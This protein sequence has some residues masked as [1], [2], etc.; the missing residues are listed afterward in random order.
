M[1]QPHALLVAS[2]GLG[3]LIPIL[4]LGNRLSSVLNIHVTILAVTSGSSSPTETEA[5][6][7]A[8]ARTICQITEIPSVDVDNLVEPDATIFTK[9]VVKMRAMKPAVRDAVKLMKRKPTVMIVDFLGTELM[10]V[11]DD[12]GMTAK[13]VYVPTHAWFLAVMVYLPVLDTVVEGEYVDI[14]EPLK[15]PGCKPV[16]PKELMETML[17]RSGQQYK[18]CVRAGLEVPMSDGV[19]V[20][21]WE[22]LQGNTLAALREDEELSRVMK[23]PVYPIGPIV[24][25]NQHVDKPNSIFEWLDEQRERSVVF[26]CLG[27]GG[28]LTFEQT[29]ELALGL[30]LS[31]Q[32][33]VWVLRRPAS[34]LGAISSDDEQ[35]SASLPEGLAP[36]ELGV[37]TGHLIILYSNGQNDVILY[38]DSR[39]T[40]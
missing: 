23:V 18:E 4:E 29:V 33:F 40:S 7:A 11:A 17:D 30:E 35:V 14:K 27:S 8:A 31:G 12:V 10:S 1:D 37:K 38:R 3:H 24:R 28:T 39:I 16:G 25:T 32:R 34:Y 21:T 15:I 9:M 19:L 6:H 26:V 36:N 5:I 2:P 20:N 22:E 13:Y